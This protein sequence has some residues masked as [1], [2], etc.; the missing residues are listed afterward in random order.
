VSKILS[1]EE[2]IRLIKKAQ[3]G[4]SVS[5]ICKKVQV[6]RAIFYKWLK[7]YENAGSR[8]KKKAL[9][10]KYLSGNR[11]WKKLSTTVEK[12]I[13]KIAIKDS[14]FSSQKIAKI[15]GVSKSGVFD[16]LK[17]HGLNT[18]QLREDYIYRNGKSL[19]KEKSI[20]YKVTMVRRHEAGDRV[21]DICRN[22]D[23]SRTIFYRWLKR[24]S[25]KKNYDEEV[26][27]EALESLRPK[28]ERHWRFVPEAK[29]LVLSVVTEHPEYS[30]HKISKV[31]FQKDNRHILSSYGVH[32]LLSRL[33]LTT[34]QRRLAYSKTVSEA[35]AGKVSVPQVSEDWKAPIF[36]QIPSVSAQ[37]PP[38]TKA[39]GGQASFLFKKV[40]SSKFFFPLLSVITISFIFSV[41]LN[42]LQYGQG[43]VGK[44]GIL[45]SFLALFLGMFFFIYSMKYYLTIAI[46]LSFSRR[47][48]EGNRGDRGNRVPGLNSDI[49]SVRLE[50]HP[51]VSIHIAS[52][53]EKRV[54]ERLLKAATSQDYD[55]YEIVI[56]D[57]SNDETTQIITTYQS[58]FG[59]LRTSLGD[60][61]ALDECEIRSGLTLKHLHR[62]S[63]SGFKGGAL[64]G[65]LNHT[66][67]RAEYILIFDADFIPYPDTIIQFLKY[68]QATAGT[69]DFVS[70]AQ[71][72]AEPYAEQSGS[73][74][75]SAS[76]VQLSSASRV[77]AVQ[78]YQW[79][80]LNKSENWITRG[81]RS[82]Y[83]GSYVIERS[84]EEIYSGLK[85]ISGSV[86]MIRKDV[87]SSIGWGTSIT[88][89]FE[90]T[91]KLYEKGYKVIYTPYIQ[92]PAEGVSTIKR[93]IRQRMRWAEGHSHNIRKMFMR[94]MFG[95]WE[96]D[97]TIEDRRWKIGVENRSLKV[98]APSSTLHPQNPPST[99]N[100]L[101]SKQ[102]T[103]IPSLLTLP[104]KL[105]FLYLSPYYL[106][107]AFFILGTMSWFIAEVV[108]KVR[109]PFWT[110]VW[111][112]SLV[113]TNLLALPLLNMVGLFLEESDEKDYLGLFS[114][115]VL[116]YIVAPFQAYAAIKGFISKEEGPWF[117]TPK[118]GKITD[119]FT[120]GKLYKIIFGVFGKKE[121]GIASPALGSVIPHF[122][123]DDNPYIALATSNN[124][125]NR[126]RIRSRKARWIGRTVLAFL[127]IVSMSIYHLTYKVSEVHATN[128]SGVFNIDS[129]ASAN[130]NT[131]W[132]FKDGSYSA[133]SSS[134]KNSVAKN[135]GT[136]Q[137]IPGTDNSTAGTPST[138]SP[139]GN[140][141]IWDTEFGPQGSIADGDWLFT[142]CTTDSD[143]DGKAG[144]YARYLA[145]KVAL[146]GTAPN[147]TIASSTNFFD[148][149]SSCSA[150]NLWTG[151]TNANRACIT[152]PSGTTYD[153]DGTEK[154]LYMEIWDEV[155]DANDDN[156]DNEVFIAGDSS[157]TTDPNIDAPST[158]IPENIAIL[159]FFTPFMPFLVRFLRKRRD[160]SA[161]ERLV[162][163][164]KKRLKDYLGDRYRIY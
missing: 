111:G 131:S 64:K 139:T 7:T 35:T 71:N 152:N 143:S 117:R 9:T 21:A 38:F 145:W 95:K 85:Q 160:V 67:P 30:V 148:T 105:E 74:R 112:W 15:V 32:T 43:I 158:T 68:F 36:G 149:T 91:L 88:E 115:I 102:R 124:T 150:S 10:P 153:F 18:K 109:L 54:V 101:P 48:E 81:V 34:Y 41:V 136:F 87:L 126:F 92:A 113:F 138:S 122:A 6:S 116:S 61:Y 76:Q 78:G 4:D 84:G 2:K 50:R 103:W 106:Q 58:S 127:L 14:S 86:Y 77:A 114:F 90:L 3:K 161:R 83:A 128:P 140:G 66:D 123:L 100:H 45:F 57:D 82:E 97:L 118:T 147:M 28:G 44:V 73:Q 19:V 125:F 96:E 13:L 5:K 159:I 142:L 107:A 42:N 26:K 63:R 40:I 23:V 8:A 133:A 47:K 119:V 79:H 55:N 89:D 80:V 60:G 11:H 134:T 25:A 46:V 49:S 135:S 104:E 53:N 121:S 98:D 20:S 157:C 59:K 120:P 65:A 31:L 37:A 144:G 94:L 141:W 52:Y 93:L 39:S 17:K 72:N 16:V 164:W 151:G 155:T 75:S 27:R 29:N 163:E 146:T 162:P 137:Y 132:Q 70:Q 130:I 1:V 22:F 51:F 56:A 99:F 69:L 154:Y 156:T 24:Y 108:F 12:K 110:E 129:A 62:T 33:N